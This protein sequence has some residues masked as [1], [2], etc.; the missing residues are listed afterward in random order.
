[1]GRSAIKILRTPEMRKQSVQKRLSINGNGIR[2]SELTMSK[3][4]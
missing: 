2:H 4:Q 1:M 3:A